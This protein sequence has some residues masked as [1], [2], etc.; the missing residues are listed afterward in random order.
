MQTLYV[1]DHIYGSAFDQPHRWMLIDGGKVLDLG[2]GDSPKAEVTVGFP[3][4]TIFP[5]LVDAHVHLSWTGFAGRGVNLFSTTSCEELLS[6]A[7]RDLLDG[8]VIGLGFDETRW[9][10]GR[11][12]T[13]AELDELSGRLPVMLPR[14][15]SYMLLANTSALHE[16]QVLLLDGVERD[17]HGEPTG[18]LRGKAAAQL[19]RWYFDRIPREEI[20]RAQ[21]WAVEAAV[22]HGITSVQEMTL[23]DKRGRRDGEILL[24]QAGELAATVIVYVADLDIDYVESL[25]V[26]TIGGDLFL[27]G[28]IG[29]RTAAV[30]AGYVGGGNGEL[31]YDDDTVRTFVAEAHRR[32][33]Q[34][35]MHVIGDVAIEQALRAWESLADPMSPQDKSQLRARRHRLEHFELALDEQMRR[36]ADLGLS[37]SVQPAFDVLWGTPGLMYEQRLGKGVANAMNLFLRMRNA[38][39]QLGGG[40]DTPV[41]PVDPRV[42]LWGLENHHDSSERWDRRSALGLFTVGAAE[43]GHLEPHK[44]RLAPGMDADF[45]VYEDDPLTV[46]DIRELR[47]LRTV[48]GGRTVYEA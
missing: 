13:L 14:V 1:A 27:D 12:P 9:A 6:R 26:H 8:G 38:D 7:R 37:I 4:A 24:E 40:S 17:T 45:A 3:G 15:D 20:A 5:G 30:S 48:A 2:D 34:V 42:G 23:P 22:A 47:L 11:L 32:G 19:Q 39:L 46:T 43:I 21:A 35:A 31:T 33:F 16:A 36:A 44:G 25:G 10:D 29:A 41:S 28:S 18:V